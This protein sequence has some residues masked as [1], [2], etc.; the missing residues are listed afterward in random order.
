MEARVPVP[1][2]QVVG[3]RP[4]LNEE[5]RSY[6]ETHELEPVEEKWPLAVTLRFVVASG[7][8]FWTAIGF[9]ISEVL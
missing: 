3:F 9:L 6:R 4:F 8:L 5:E 7:V 1:G 2:S